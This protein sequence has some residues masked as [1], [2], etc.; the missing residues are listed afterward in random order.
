MVSALLT[1]ERETKMVKKKVD[2]DLINTL[3]ERIMKGWNKEIDLKIAKSTASAKTSL[4]LKGVPKTPEHVE[5]V[6][7]SLLGGVRSDETRKRIS[8]AK[9]GITYP[10]RKP[11]SEEAK[12]NVAIANSRKIGKTTKPHT[13]ETKRKIS[14][15]H[16][17]TKHWYDDKEAARAVLSTK[18]MDNS[19]K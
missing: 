11:L 5:N 12:K 15:K 7:L 19:K 1:F 17:G 4:A 16:K 6:R 14:E 3:N 10:N 2:I 18:Y 9:T 8:L 13:K